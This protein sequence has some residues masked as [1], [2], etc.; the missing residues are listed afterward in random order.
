M[1]DTFRTTWESMTYFSLTCGAWRLAKIVSPGVQDIGSCRA[2][3]IVPAS[4]LWQYP[5]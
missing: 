1:S 5:R 2:D 4:C 3:Q